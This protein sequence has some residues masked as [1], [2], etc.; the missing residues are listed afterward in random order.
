VVEVAAVHETAAFSA[1]LLRATSPDCIPGYRLVAQAVHRHGAKVFGQLFHP[2]REIQS[3]SD[4]MMAVAWAPSAVPNERFHIMPKPMPEALIEEVIAGYGWAAGYP[5]EGGLEGVEVVASQGYL[6]AQFLTR[7]S[8]AVPTAGAAARRT[9]C[10][11]SKR[12]SPRCA[13]RSATP[14]WGCASRA[15]SSTPRRV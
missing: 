10:A 14:P 2:G 7:A 5:V 4:G 3:T 1:N 11:F 13:A 6:P 15:T 9:A 8:T 12:S